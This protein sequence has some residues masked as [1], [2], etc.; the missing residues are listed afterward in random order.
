VKNTVVDIYSV[1]HIIPH[2]IPV[3]Q[4]HKYLEKKGEKMNCSKKV[5]IP[6][7]VPEEQ[8]SKYV[9]MK[10][11]IGST[12][13]IK[14]IVPHYIPFEQQEKYLAKKFLTEKEEE[15]DIHEQS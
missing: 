6:K 11:E 2:Y 15:N 4:W 14:H 5:H 12:Y 13:K 3:G 10:L 7:Y 1:L 8:H 9:S